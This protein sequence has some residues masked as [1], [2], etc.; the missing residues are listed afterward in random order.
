MRDEVN[1]R[2]QYRPLIVEIICKMGTGD[3]DALWMTL[4]WE[5]PHWLRWGLCYAAW[6]EESKVQLAVAVRREKE[7]V[8]AEWQAMIE[9]GQLELF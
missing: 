6:L 2:E 4:K 3:I 8:A 7:R 1:W 9:A 5:Y